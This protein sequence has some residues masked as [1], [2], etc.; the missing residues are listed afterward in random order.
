MN[1]AN[2][3]AFKDQRLVQIF[4]RYATYNGSSPYLCPATLN[5]IAHVEIVKGAFYPVEGMVSITSS[6]VQLAQRISV[7]NLIFHTAVRE[8]IN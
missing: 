7:C 4:N 2:E 1:G 8:I 6:L 3:K 5:V